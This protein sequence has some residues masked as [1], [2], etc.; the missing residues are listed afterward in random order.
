MHREGKRKTSVRMRANRYSGQ[1]EGQ[2]CFERTGESFKRI[3]II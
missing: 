3:C 1:V 2:V